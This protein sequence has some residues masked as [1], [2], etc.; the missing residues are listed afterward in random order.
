[1]NKSEKQAR[2]LYLHNKRYIEENLDR[3]SPRELCTFARK[4]DRLYLIFNG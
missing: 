4:Q 2:K 1:M 3:L